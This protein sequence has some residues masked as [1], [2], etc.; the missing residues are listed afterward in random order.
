VSED[1]AA[2]TVGRPGLHL[3]VG[4]RPPL[5]SGRYSCGSGCRNGRA[6]KWCWHHHH[7]VPCCG[8]CWSL[9]PAAFDSTTYG[10][11]CRASSGAAHAAL[12]QPRRQHRATLQ[13]GRRR[14]AIFI[15]LLLMLREPDGSN[16]HTT[17][18]YSLVSRPELLRTRPNKPNRTE[19]RISQKVLVINSTGFDDGVS[20]PVGSVRS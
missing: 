8:L 14:T 4:E 5:C 12:A 20:H 15:K 9:A 19:Q 3:V 7:V 1:R 11:C 18:L 17:I 2:L 16:T 6:N 10:R 13:G